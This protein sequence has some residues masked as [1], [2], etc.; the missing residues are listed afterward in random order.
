M[1]QA[2][3]FSQA[4]PAQHVL[5]VRRS[6]C[7]RVVCQGFKRGMQQTSS[8]PAGTTAT[9][10][11]PPEGEAQITIA[12][13]IEQAPAAQQQSQSGFSMAWILVAAAVAA[14][15]VFKKLKSNDPSRGE[16]AGAS[17]SMRACAHARVAVSSPLLACVAA[18]CTVLVSHNCDTLG[19]MLCTVLVLSC[20]VHAQHPG[21]GDGITGPRDHCSSTGTAQQ[22]KVRTQLKPGMQASTDR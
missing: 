9:A 1:L 14:G 5:P 13:P 18:F 6:S 3:L 17:G 20:R 19:D 15:L 7:S 8:A 2:Q 22:G 4:R 12:V 16:Y 10:G 21:H 11:S